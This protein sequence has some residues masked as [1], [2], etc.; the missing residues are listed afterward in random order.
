MISSQERRHDNHDYTVGAT[1]D[2][3]QHLADDGIA[4]IAD[5]LAD[6]A[7]IEISRTIPDLTLPDVLVE[8]RV[9]GRLF[10][11][12]GV[13][14]ALEKARRGSAAKRC[15]RCRQVKPSHC[16]GRHRCKPDGLNYAC[17]ECERSADRKKLWRQRRRNV[18]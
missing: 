16:F 14:V 8:V 4:I 18:G 2:Q 6:H 10:V 13:A 11:A 17:K 12:R 5:L 7:T 9:G 3:H 1:P 15:S